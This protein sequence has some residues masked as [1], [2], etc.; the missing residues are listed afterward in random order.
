MRFIHIL[1]ISALFSCSTREKADILSFKTGHFTTYLGERKDSSRFYRTENFQ[2]ET[3]K[4]KIDTF[5]I[6]WKN[7][8]EYQLRKTNP[9][10]K[11]DS[12][13]FIVKIT[14]IKSN[15]YKFKGSYLGSNFK[16][17]GVIYKN[18]Q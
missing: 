4:N 12:I 8:F 11:L 9:K 16:Q 17:E 15:Y 6:H 18:K 7:N 3:Y 2:F 1:L 5:S 14:G 10:N 13:P